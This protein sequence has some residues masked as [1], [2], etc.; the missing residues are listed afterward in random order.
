MLDVYMLHNAQVLENDVAARL[1]A[2]VSPF[3]YTTSAMG[4][5]DWQHEHHC[6]V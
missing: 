6:P 5:H 1:C 3:K 2:F 4:V